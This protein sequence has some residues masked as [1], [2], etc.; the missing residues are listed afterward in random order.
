MS[1]PTLLDHI[2]IAGPSLEELVDWFR[3]L[4]GVTATPG[5]AHP[6]GTVNALV[7]L[8]VAGQR[9]PHY[10]ELVGPDPERASAERPPGQRHD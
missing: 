10:L 3:D 4:T 2:V 8:T 7:A 9:R 6:V 1:I 5:G